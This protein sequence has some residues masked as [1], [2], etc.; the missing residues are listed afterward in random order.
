M[1]NGQLNDPLN[2]ITKEIRKISSKR[3]KTDADQ[4][5]MARLEWHGGLYL[6]NG[7]P[8]IPGEVLEA[9]I[10]NAAKK[11]KRGKQAQATIWCSGNYPIEYNGPKTIDE[12]W[13]ANGDFRL[14]CRARIGPAGVMRTRPIFREW[15]ALIEIRFDDTVLNPAE[16][17]EIV[18]TAGEVVGLMDWRPR[19]GRFVVV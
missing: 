7:K 4:E 1:H 2:S 9:T 10:F 13:A 19:F 8:C 15:S 11:T 14:T 18:V 5:E 6:H 16:I 3:G 17:R 12:L